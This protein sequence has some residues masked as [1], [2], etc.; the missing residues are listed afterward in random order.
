MPYEIDAAG[1]KVCS[2]NDK[3]QEECPGPPV[4]TLNEH[5]PPA[6]E[7]SRF[8]PPA[9]LEAPSVPHLFPNGNSAPPPFPPSICTR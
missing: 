8:S 7:K 9:K 4:E 6:R 2:N 1:E 3:V 5:S